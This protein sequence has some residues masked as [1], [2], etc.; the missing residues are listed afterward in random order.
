M[1]P[2]VERDDD[3]DG[4]HEDGRYGG[5]L[6]DERIPVRHGDHDRDRAANAPM[7]ESEGL[8]QLADGRNGHGRAP[9]MVRL[10]LTLDSSIQK[11]EAI[12]CVRRRSRRSSASDSRNSWSGWSE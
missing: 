10:R 8:G 12:A 4:I 1:A 3:H 9:S 2:E 11:K 5:F 7:R 6:D